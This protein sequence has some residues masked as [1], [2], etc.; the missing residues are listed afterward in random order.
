[1]VSFTALLAL[2]ASA[3]AAPAIQASDITAQA[4][5]P[6]NWAWHVEGWSMGCTGS[7]CI[8]GFNVTVPSIEGK[9]AGVKA[10]CVGNENGWYRKGNWY[11]PCQILEGVNNGVS[12]KFSERVDDNGTYP[13]QILLSFAKTALDPLDG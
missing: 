2:S 6:A 10:Y 1:M 8:Y 7:G 4:T 9:I 5:I 12:A 13:D 3:L 11:K